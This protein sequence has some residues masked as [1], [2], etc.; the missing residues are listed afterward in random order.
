ML[1]QKVTSS[2][3]VISDHFKGLG[4]KVHILTQVQEYT[5]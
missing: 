3:S 4:T 5:Y 1:T 2:L